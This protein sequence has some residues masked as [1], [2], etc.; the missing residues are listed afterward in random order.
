MLATILHFIVLALQLL[1]VTIT[2]FRSCTFVI[3]SFPSI[4]QLLFCRIL[5][6]CSASI[7]GFTIRLHAGYVF[8][9]ME[10][11]VECVDLWCC[12]WAFFV[13]CNWINSCVLYWFLWMH[14]VVCYASLKVS[15]SKSQ[16]MEFYRTLCVDVVRA[17]VYC[18]WCLFS[19][20]FLYLLF[21]ERQNP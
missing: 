15:C 14:Y 13:T 7:Y 16:W 6:A 9:N 20:M 19:F 21:Q 4:L 10:L 5:I 1:T 12:W 3:F 8:V 18:S 17:K 11:F 2:V